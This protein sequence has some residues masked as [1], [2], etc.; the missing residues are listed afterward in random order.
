MNNN[1]K[2]KKMVFHAGK[3]D[4]GFHGNFFGPPLWM[5]LHIMAAAF[6]LG[7][8]PE[9]TER[10]LA[11]KVML[12]T[13]IKCLPC[14]DCRENSRFMIKI[15]QDLDFMA[16]TR[17]QLKDIIYTFHNQVNKKLGKKVL[18]KAELKQMDILYETGRTGINEET[19]QDQTPKCGH[20]CIHICHR[21]N[22]H[23]T[24]FN[25]SS[26]IID[27]KCL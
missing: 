7:K 14:K 12:I 27:K 20:T 15:L 19:Q 23:K 22:E 21:S 3:Q 9:E 1:I 24:V 2:K 6:P 4:D 11:Y 25:K 17:D 10:R 5:S 13:I 18:S 8:S 26:I 16:L